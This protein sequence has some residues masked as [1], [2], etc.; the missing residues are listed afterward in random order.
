MGYF[1]CIRQ[2]K[3]RIEAMRMYGSFFRSP[4]ILFLSGILLLSAVRVNAQPSSNF[5]RVLLPEGVSVELPRNWVA[6]SNNEKFTL[7][8]AVEAAL[9]FTKIVSPNSTLPFAANYYDDSGKV[10][11]MLNI[12]YYPKLDISQRDVAE[13]SATDVGELDVALKESL[14]QSVGAIGSNITHWKGTEKVT[15]SGIVAFKTEYYRRSLRSNDDFRVRL[16]RVFAGP[17]SFTLTVSYLASDIWILEKITDHII[18]SLR[19]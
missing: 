14:A 18:A 4:V 1:G 6:L 7:D 5:T 12:R 19:M 11:A 13:A 15:I 10:V 17:R 8:T 2:E 16:V 9:D 3:T